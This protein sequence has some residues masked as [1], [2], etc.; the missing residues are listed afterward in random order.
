MK[1]TELF[2][3]F[4]RPSAQQLRHCEAERPSAFAVLRLIASTHFVG[5]CTGCRSGGMTQ[6]SVGDM[7]H[8]ADPR[9]GVVHTRRS[10]RFAQLSAHWTKASTLRYGVCP[11]SFTAGAQARYGFFSR[12]VT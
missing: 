1:L 9:D 4:V 2:D 12:N 6:D 11:R 7:D 10:D 5:C 8:V 3:G